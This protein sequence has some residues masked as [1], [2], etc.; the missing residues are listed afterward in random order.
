MEK[1]LNT[2]MRELREYEGWTQFDLSEKLNVS[3]A[4]IKGWETGDHTPTI[5]N[6]K[7]IRDLCDRA[8]IK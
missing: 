3:I 2:K 7:K 1:P 5:R 6:R 8:G 4:S